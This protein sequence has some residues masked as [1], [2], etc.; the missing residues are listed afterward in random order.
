MSA[1]YQDSAV[2]LYQGDAWQV[3]RTLPGDSVDAVIT[4]PPYS[5]GA[6]TL[7]GKQAPAKI[8]YQNTGTVKQYPEM[9]GDGKDQ[10]SF[11]TWAIMWLTEAWR[12][13]RPGTARRF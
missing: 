1:Y 6:V 7:V 9:L 3:L 13:V 10:R 5:T 4:D 11:L 12:V 8:K 2:T